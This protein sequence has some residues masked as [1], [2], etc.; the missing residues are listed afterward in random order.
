VRRS[1]RTL[2]L[3]V[4]VI[5]AAIASPSRLHARGTFDLNVTITDSPDPV[6]AGSNITYTI[7]VSNL[8]G[9]PGSS[10]SVTTGWGTG[11][12]FT[13]M[14]AA[15][16]W[17]ITS[18]PVGTN[19]VV[20]ASKAG[21]FNPGAS[22]TFTLITTV[23]GGTANGTV[24]T[25]TAQGSSS[26]SDGTPANNSASTTTTVTAGVPVMSPW[27]LGLLLIALLGVC[28]MAMRSRPA[29]HAGA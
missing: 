5:V 23:G 18:P 3:F 17:T 7:T 29:S 25:A 19:D 8:G 22:Q 24:I 16:G 28:W 2:S 6:A 21:L 20:I 10:V 1:L 27:Q 9:G 15:A 13:S 4:A 12:T 14:S 26:P 11:A